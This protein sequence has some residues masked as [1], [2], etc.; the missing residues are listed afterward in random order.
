MKFEVKIEGKWTGEIPMEHLVEI[1]KG[2]DD[3]L[4]EIYRELNCDKK[5]CPE[6]VL[7]GLKRGSTCLELDIKPV[8]DLFSQEIAEKVFYK[9][10]QTVKT[11]S[12]INDSNFAGETSS[13]RHF[14]RI[15]K[16]IDEKTGINRIDFIFKTERIS[17][18]HEKARKLLEL[19][20]G[21]SVECKAMKIS[22]AI[23][24]IDSSKGKCKIKS[25]LLGKIDCTYPIHLEEKLCELL[26]PLRKSVVAEGEMEFDPKT[27]KYK[28]F[29]IQKIQSA[30]DYYSQKKEQPTPTNW[31]KFAG[32]LKNVSPEKSA[33]EIT[34][35]MIETIWGD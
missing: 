15:A 1:G 27:G 23:V 9:F 2:L 6:L 11:I 3:I 5:H 26:K 8:N 31:R 4:Q 30:A 17:I 13:V 22:G 21:L 24:E 14:R 19:S 25:P 33:D 29:H 7:S 20:E 35:W 12:H 28:I 34:N 16:I 18:T 32:S 10:T